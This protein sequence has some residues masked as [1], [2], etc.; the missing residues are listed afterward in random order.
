MISISFLE[1]DKVMSDNDSDVDTDNTVHEE[2]ADNVESIHFSLDKKEIE[3][4]R[5]RD[6]IEAFLARGGMIRQIPE[7]VLADPPK[8]PE[9]NYGGQPI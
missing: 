9:S 2:G 1:K 6:E 8:K 7:N 4:Q 5:L 3:R